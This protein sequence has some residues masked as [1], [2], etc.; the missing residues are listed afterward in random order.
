MHFILYNSQQ[1]QQQLD[2]NAIKWIEKPP[3]QGVAPSMQWHGRLIS[4]APAPNNISKQQKQTSFIPLFDSQINAFDCDKNGSIHPSS[5]DTN[6]IVIVCLLLIEYQYTII[7]VSHFIGGPI[8]DHMQYHNGLQLHVFAVRLLIWYLLVMRERE[9]E[10]EKSVLFS[11][12]QPMPNEK[13]V[14]AFMLIL[15]IANRF[16]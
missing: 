2:M 5:N 14:P 4:I 6:L 16:A 7:A 8:N 11:F 9:R 12:R 1:Q 3:A 10:R 13:R 15:H